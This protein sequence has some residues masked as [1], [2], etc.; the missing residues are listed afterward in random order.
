MAEGVGAGKVVAV[1]FAARGEHTQTVLQIAATDSGRT[2]RHMQVK[3][4][5]CNRLG[6]LAGC[7]YC[8][9]TS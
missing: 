9:V 1:V 2:A 4:K 6:L 8:P 7:L 5:G 3:S